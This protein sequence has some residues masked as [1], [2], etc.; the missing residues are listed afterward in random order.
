MEVSDFFNQTAAAVM[1]GAAMWMTGR[2]EQWSRWG[3]M[4]GLLAQPFWIATFVHNHQWPLLVMDAWYT[5]SWAQ[6]VYYKLWRK[7]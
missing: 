4:V 6:G 7:S 5:Y 3:F 1:G 2:P